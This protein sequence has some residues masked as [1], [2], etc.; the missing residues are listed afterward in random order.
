MHDLRRLKPNEG[1]L[2]ASLHRSAG[3]LIPGY[4]TLDRTSESFRDF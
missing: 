1:D 4:V 2:A 3:A